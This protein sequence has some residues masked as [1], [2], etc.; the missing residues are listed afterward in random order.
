[1]QTNYLLVS[2]NDFPPK[3]N[4]GQT[5]YINACPSLAFGRKS[6]IDANK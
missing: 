5:K 6:N 3:A 2:I 1:M 4:D